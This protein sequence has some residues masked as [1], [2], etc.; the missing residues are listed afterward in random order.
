MRKKASMRDVFTNF[1]RNSF[2]YNFFKE[3]DIPDKIF[4]KKAPDGTVHSIP[5][6][7]V[8]EFIA[9]TSRSEKRQI[10]KILRQIDLANGDVNHFLNHLAQAIADKY[11]R[12]ASRKK[13]MKPLTKA[14]IRIA[15]KHPEYRKDLIPIILQ[16]KK[17]EEDDKEGRFEEGKG[18]DPTKNM[19]EKDKEKW[20][21]YHGKVEGLK[22]KKAALQEQLLRRELTKL[23]F[24]HP[25]FR[26]D[27]LPILVG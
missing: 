9:Q 5:N 3:K 4:N 2:F 14:L 11:G 15:S 22:K 10:E 13:P 26:K 20:E 1:P 18:A 24:N 25:E 12:T 7:V 27:I 21:K 6:A 16:A 17:E 19:S 8:V 23:A